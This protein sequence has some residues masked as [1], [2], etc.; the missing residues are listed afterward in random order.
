VYEEERTK[1]PYQSM[2]MTKKYYDYK[3]EFQA[4]RENSGIRVK[5]N[6]ET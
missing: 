5:E 2:K 4:K 3:Y 6:T 1:Y